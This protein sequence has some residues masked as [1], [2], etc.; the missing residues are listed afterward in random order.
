MNLVEETSFK[1]I[2]SES[3]LGVFKNIFILGEIF[4]IL[5]ALNLLKLL[6]I[7]KS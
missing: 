5:S 4:L 7:F 1:R 2:L 6:I 3:I